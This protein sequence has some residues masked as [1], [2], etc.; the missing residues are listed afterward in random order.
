MRGHVVKLYRNEVTGAVEKIDANSIETARVGDIV[1]F[2]EST[3]IDRGK[4][5]LETNRIRPDVNK[6]I[7][8][9]THVDQTPVIGDVA[10]YWDDATGWHLKRAVP[11]K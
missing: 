11:G 3:T 1:V 6:I 10:F 4:F 2:N 8:P 9:A 5:D 7:F